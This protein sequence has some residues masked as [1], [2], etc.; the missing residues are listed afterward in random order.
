MSPPSIGPAYL[1]L[2]LITSASSQDSDKPA[3]S[4]E[5]EEGFVQTL[6]QIKKNMS[7]SGNRSENY[8]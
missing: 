2:V 7:V 6:G 8:R 5:V 1:I 4:I 3:Q